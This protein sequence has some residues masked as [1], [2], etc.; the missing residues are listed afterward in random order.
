MV[1]KLVYEFI[2][3]FM[4]TESVDVSY[5]VTGSSGTKVLS[6]DIG[7]RDDYI[8]KITALTG[9]NFNSKYLSN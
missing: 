8:I 5:L 4:R 6:E 1:S 9:N 2:H 3:L 7:I